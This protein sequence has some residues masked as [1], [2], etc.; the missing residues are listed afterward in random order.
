MVD[1]A[2][3]L[4]RAVSQELPFQ[5]LTPPVLL[6]CHGAHFVLESAPPLI[7][8]IGWTCL[9]VVQVYFI[10]LE[11]SGKTRLPASLS[12]PKASRQAFRRPLSLNTFTFATLGTMFISVAKQCILSFYLV[13]TPLPRLNLVKQA[14]SVSHRPL[15]CPAHESYSEGY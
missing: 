7:V 1:R 15:L 14:V 12:W 11:L 5:S 10:S 3:A 13:C 6:S 8:G 4:P 9:L 2:A